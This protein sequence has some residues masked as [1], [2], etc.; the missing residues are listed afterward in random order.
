MAIAN[1]WAVR[2]VA[3]CTA[4][5]ITTGKMLVYL[6]NLKSSDINVTSETVYARGVKNTPYR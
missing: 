3:T 2:N 5:D 6:E 1:R 4:Y